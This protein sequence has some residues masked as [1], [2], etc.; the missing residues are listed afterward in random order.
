MHNFYKFFWL[1]FFIVLCGY[2]FSECSFFLLPG[3]IFIDFISPKFAINMKKN[4]IY[5]AYFILFLYTSIAFYMILLFFIK[6]LLSILFSLYKSNTI[7]NLMIKNNIKL[8]VAHL[9][10]NLLCLGIF[11]RWLAAI[12]FEYLLASI[13][14]TFVFYLLIAFYLLTPLHK[15]RY[16][17]GSILS[18]VIFPLLFFIEFKKITMLIFNQSITFLYIVNHFDNLK[19]NYSQITYFSSYLFIPLL[20]ILVLEFRRFMKKVKR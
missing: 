9:C 4:V 2:F 1:A 10:F 18:F 16:N 7:I 5:N 11:W 20:Q 14:L 17:F 13:L 19:Y 6:K 8:F 15:F 3:S 12:T